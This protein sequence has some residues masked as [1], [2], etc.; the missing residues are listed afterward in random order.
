MGPEEALRRWEAE[1]AAVA[2]RDVP[3][4]SAWDTA[5]RVRSATVARVAEAGAV[6]D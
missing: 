3:S 6:A 4:R 2:A 1:G 5:A